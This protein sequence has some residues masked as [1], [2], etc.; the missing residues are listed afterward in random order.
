MTVDL[1]LQPEDLAKCVGCSLCLPHCPTFR[2]TGDETMSPRGRIALMRAV[3]SSGA[4]LTAEVADAFTTCVQ[5]RGCE[6]ACPS[7]VPFGRLIEGTREAMADLAPTTS[8]WK[9]LALAPLAHPRLLRGGSTL[10]ALAQRAGLVPRRLGLPRLPL[11]RPAL[12][13]SGNDVALFTGCVM[14]AWSRDTH[15]SGQRV[16][17]A[18]G[19]GV[20]PTGDAAP[21]CGAL[22]AHVGRRD[23][24]QRRARQVIASLPGD[25]P[26]LVDAAGCGAALK[27]Y[28]N[29]L[30]T[31]ESAR[32]ARRVYDIQEWV[33]A[34]LD[35]L[36]K[37]APL[38][39]RVAI[40]DPCHLRHVQRVHHATRI[41]LRPL[42][43]E[44]VEVD[45]DG[46]CCGAG[47]AYALFNPEMATAIRSRKLS[48]IESARADVVA[49]ANPGC[50]MHLTAAGVV[51]RHPMELVDAALGRTRL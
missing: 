46:L 44:L 49:S 23:L 40:Q 9:R 38:D 30:G 7:G 27:E 1:H 26:V 47:G 39:L 15:L 18:M 16:L 4:P 34:H 17:E 6:T 28:G 43:R 33:A 32:F 36:P 20:E 21:C 24:A 22:H 48:F 29:L 2:V 50:S 41:V 42:V 37:V 19:F 3:Q 51:T 11:R 31:A 25:A 13:A 14:D 45:D 35:R 8:A 10:V 12:Q 5:C